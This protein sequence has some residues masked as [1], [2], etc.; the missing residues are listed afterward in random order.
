[1][2]DNVT[3]VADLRE[4]MARFVADREWE[5]YHRPK[6][7]AMSL[8]VEVAELVEHFQWLDHEQTDAALADPRVREQVEDEMADI[9]AFLLS[10]TNA[11]SSDLSTAF[12]RKLAKNEVKYP[13]DQVRGDYRRPPRTDP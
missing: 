1:M 5:K 7:L 11:I 4:A 13:A 12:I 3:T 8:A 9:L 2:A 6:N 10:L